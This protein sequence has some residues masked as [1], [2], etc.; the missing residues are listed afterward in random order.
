MNKRYGLAAILLPALLAGCGQ[1]AAETADQPSDEVPA[2]TAARFDAE[3]ANH[4]SGAAKGCATETSGE[5]LSAAQARQEAQG[6][7]ID[8]WL[9]DV[10]RDTR[11][12]VCRYEGTFEGRSDMSLDVWEAADAAAGGPRPALDFS[13]E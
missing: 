5:R 12:Y 6:T 4:G 7:P 9:L 8:G 10:P 13:A 1:G 2:A 11:L 3:A